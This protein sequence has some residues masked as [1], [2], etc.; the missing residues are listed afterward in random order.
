MQQL[1]NLGLSAYFL[2]QLK[3]D[4]LE[5]LQLARISRV[6][7]NNLHALTPDKDDRALQEIQL[8]T[9]SDQTTGEFAVGDWVSYSPVNTEGASGMVLRSLERQSTLQR[10]AAGEDVQSQLIATNID[11]AFIM[12]S[13]NA[14]FNL[15]R[16]ERYLALVRSSDIQPVIILSKS[17]LAEDIYQFKPQAEAIDPLIPVIAMDT[18]DP[19]RIPALMD[20]WRKGQTAVLLGSS[21]VGKSTLLNTLSGGEEATAGIREDDAKGRHTTTARS[22]FSI[23]NDRWLIDTPGMRALRLYGVS[24]GIQAV[25]SDLEQLAD[26]CRFADC[27]HSNE[28]GCAIQAAI[29][30]GELE[31]KRLQRWQKLQ[32]EE[33]YN[34]ESIHESRA[35]NKAFGKMIKRVSSESRR[36]KGQ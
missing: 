2:Q 19:A 27:S 32:R 14:D 3:A 23:A 17:D 9:P 26:Q 10:R 33:Q 34:S 15:A 8:L 4:E 1:Q 22:L 12:T 36:M 5:T 21:G 29:I 11:V 18:R 28:P 20:W 25:F 24:E 35:R 6:N 30:A 13:C 16:L 7:R 31:P